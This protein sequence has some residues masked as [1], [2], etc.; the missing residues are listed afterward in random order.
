MTKIGPLTKLKAFADDKFNVVEMLI[1]LFDGVENI[2]GKGK[3]LVA[4]I[5]SCSHNI[6]ER[7]LSQGCSAGI[8]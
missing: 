4:S 2:V 6:F 8:V 5:F 1:S 7:L 3:M